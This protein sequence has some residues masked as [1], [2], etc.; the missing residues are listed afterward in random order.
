MRERGEHPIDSVALVDESLVR[1]AVAEVNTLVLREGLRATVKL[2]KYLLKTVLRGSLADLDGEGTPTWRALAASPELTVAPS[3]LWFAV[4]TV[5]QLELLPREVGRALS[6]SHHRRLV[7]VQ[8]LERKRELA[9]RAAEE[10]WTVRQLDV[11]IG[12]RPAPAPAVRDP[13]AGVRAGIGGL[14]L[15]AF[16]ADALAAEPRRRLLRWRRDL[17]EARSSLHTLLDRLGVEP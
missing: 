13:L 4:K 3:T 10:G 15:D 14:D 17:R 1:D 7:A 8:D 6:P 11:A 5:E 2:G 12:N 16:G 9:A